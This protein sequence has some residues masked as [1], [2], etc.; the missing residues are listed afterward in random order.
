M[1]KRNEKNERIKLDYLTFLEQ[2]K[3][4]SEKTTD[5]VAAALDRFQDTTVRRDFAGFNKHQAIRFKKVLAESKNPQT[6]APLAK[7]TIHSQ[8]AHLKA[9]YLWLAGQPGYRRTLS[10]SDAE[11]FNPSGLEMRRA[12]APRDRPIPTIEQIRHVLT[13]TPA[14]TPV[15]R[16]DRAIIAFTLLSGARD[17]A[18]ASLRLGNVNLDTRRVF[19]DARTVRTK[20]GKTIESWL[21]R[22]G[23]DFDDIL[24]DWVAYLRAECLFGETD[25]LFPPQDM[26]PDETGSFAPSGFRRTPWKDA[27]AIRRIF[28]EAFERAG[29][30]YCNPHS[31]RKTLALHG[32]A[33]CTSAEQLKAWSQNLGH[34]DMLVTLTSYG[35]IPAH[36]QAELIGQIAARPPA[37]AA[38]PEGEPPPEVIKWVFEH[39]QRKAGAG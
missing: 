32:Q 34:E 8:L 17:D 10:Y 16:R 3:H 27:G 39:V 20:N 21:F 22:L 9:F 18:I 11:Y 36:R 25:P 2:A 33:V 19:Q 5:D 7:T 15:Q 31:F 37:G 14:E 24:R 26:A 12:S 13:V 23:D 38:L 1:P 30:P 4:L 28:K 35:T 6:G 29:L